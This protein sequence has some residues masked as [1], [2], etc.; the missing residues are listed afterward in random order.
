MQDTCVWSLGWEDPLEKGKATYSIFW[1][2]EFHGL[3]S[4]WGHKESDTTEQLS[5]PVRC[6]VWLCHRPA[7][8]HM[9]HLWAWREEKYL[10][11]ELLGDQLNFGESGNK[12]KRKDD[13]GK[14]SLVSATYHINIYIFNKH[15]T[16]VS[17]IQ[18]WNTTYSTEII[19]KFSYMPFICLSSLHTI[20]ILNAILFSHL[21]V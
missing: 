8:S 12:I 5:L 11:F 18:N 19:H 1:P 2:G 16:E 6:L 17:Q 4:P 3:Y 20:A 21:N 15:I 13:F 10:H 9:P 14:Q 7:L